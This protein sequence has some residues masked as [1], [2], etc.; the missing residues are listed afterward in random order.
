[1]VLE[2]WAGIVIGSGCVMMRGSGCLL[3]DLIV[4][5]TRR[6]LGICRRGLA[7]AGFCE[8]VY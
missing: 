3:Q 2:R 8:R 1:M 6:T 7:Y 5:A 4:G